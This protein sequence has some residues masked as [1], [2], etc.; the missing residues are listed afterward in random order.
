MGEDIGEKLL[1]EHHLITLEKQ[2]QAMFMKLCFNK[3]L[4]NSE[5]TT[6]NEKLFKYYPTV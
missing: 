2:E 5:I 3:A 1:L 6:I 4:N